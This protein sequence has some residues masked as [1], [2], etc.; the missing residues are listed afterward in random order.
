MH[1]TPPRASGWL[2]WDVYWG[3][4]LAFDPCPNRF[5]SLFGGEP[6]RFGGLPST[7]SLQFVWS[8]VVWRFRGG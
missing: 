3:Y 5:A 2:D 8:P 4:D 7:A 1:C 6:N